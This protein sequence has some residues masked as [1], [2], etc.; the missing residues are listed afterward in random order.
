[1]CTIIKLFADEVYIF[2]VQ[3]LGKSI[4][5]AVHRTEFINETIRLPLASTVAWFLRFR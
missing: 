2:I 5:V 1:M 4:I 3:I